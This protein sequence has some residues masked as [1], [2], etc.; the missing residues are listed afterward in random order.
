[1]SQPETDKTLKSFN[2][3]PILGNL[4]RV[5][6]GKEFIIVTQVGPRADF[7]RFLVFVTVEGVPTRD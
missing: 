2:I 1:M 3:I 4:D 5:K 7:F 6:S